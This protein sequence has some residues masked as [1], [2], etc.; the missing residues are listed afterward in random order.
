MKI[1]NKF[2]AS[3]HFDEALAEKYE[4]R[5]R[6]FCPSYDILHDLIALWFR[7]LPERA[8]FLSVG[9]G[10]GA[11]V[12]LLGR[13]FPLW[14][15]TALDVSRDMLEVCRSRT[16][17]AG[18]DGRVTFVCGPI[19]DF[20]TSSLFD[21]A[22]SIFVSHFVKGRI[23][24]IA[25]FTAIS[26]ALKP[27]APFVFADL[28]GDEQSPTF[29]ELLDAWLA[30]YSSQGVSRSDYEKDRAHIRNDLSFV[31][32]HDLLSLLAEA[33]FETP[34]RFYQT[35]LFGGWVTKKLR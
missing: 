8:S 2:A 19:Q 12:L 26:S 1:S 28:F 17:Q 29:S 20:A 3:A 32:E 9:A 35:L 22:S 23:N 7:D 6:S 34:V 11:E 5:I 4:R 21:A 31:P 18:M 16:K 13:I 27:G 15:F 25:Y 10:T 24:K 33:G 14:N 30:S